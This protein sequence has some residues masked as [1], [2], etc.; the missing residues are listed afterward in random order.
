MTNLVLVSKEKKHR[1]NKNSSIYTNMVFN[2]IQSW[3]F[4]TNLVKLSP[5]KVQCP[6]KIAETL[7]IAEKARYIHIVLNYLVL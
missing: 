1:R 5:P 7:K 3:L 6:V 4:N 2:Y